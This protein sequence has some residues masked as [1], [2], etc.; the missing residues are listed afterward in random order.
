M[1]NDPRPRIIMLAHAMAYM[2]VRKRR[3]QIGIASDQSIS[4][5]EL[6]A[7]MVSSHAER[8]PTKKRLQTFRKVHKLAVVSAVLYL[9][10]PDSKVGQRIDNSSEAWKQR[11]GATLLR[12]NLRVG[13][14]TLSR[15]ARWFYDNSNDHM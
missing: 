8:F 13:R 1:P 9:L 7:D 3:K 4:E 11:R 12:A 6:D 5:D 14:P 2:K 15:E 10:S